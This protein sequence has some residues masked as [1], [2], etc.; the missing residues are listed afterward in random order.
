MLINKIVKN[1]FIKNCNVM[2]NYIDT[3]IYS[4]QF[5]ETISTYIVL[6]KFNTVP[7][8]QASI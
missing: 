6:G 1:V 5:V 3:L 2:P 8:L 4:E 7:T